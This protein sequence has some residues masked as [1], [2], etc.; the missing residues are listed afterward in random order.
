[1]TR[2]AA[3]VGALLLTL[4][5]AG[6]AAANQ[7][8]YT[9][10]DAWPAE[11][12]P[13]SIAGGWDFECDGPLYY[14]GEGTWDLKLWYKTGETDPTPPNAPWP[15]LKGQYVQQGVDYFNSEPKMD[16]SEVAGTFKWTGQLTD[17][18]IGIP[19]TWRE[20]L[21]GKT[22]GITLPGYGTVFQQS[23][24]LKQT[25]IIPEDGG[26]WQ[27]VPDHEFWTGNNTFDVEALCAY[28]GYEVAALP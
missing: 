26:D 17:H 18:F 19:E 21:S 16:G 5:L 6:P 12:G 8:L 22:W 4:V 9:E 10:H 11:W 27:Y 15:W 23:G 14:A 20:S 25:T 3:L 13:V 24:N 7:V 1:M 2:M 28:F